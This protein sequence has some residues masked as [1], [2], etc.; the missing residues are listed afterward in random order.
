MCCII[1]LAAKEREKAEKAQKLAQ[2][3]KA[4]EATSRLSS[5]GPTPKKGQPSG[6]KKSG[7][8]TPLRG[9]DAQALDLSALNL[10]D[11]DEAVEAEEPPPKVTIAREKV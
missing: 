8:S 3:K 9:K 2:Q 6:S 10:K 7:T 5:A 1:Y 4:A 11:V